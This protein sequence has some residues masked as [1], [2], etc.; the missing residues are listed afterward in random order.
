MGS[1]WGLGPLRIG[2][3]TEDISAIHWFAASRLRRRGQS[4]HPAV[5]SGSRAETRGSTGGTVQDT[6]RTNEKTA[7]NPGTSR[8]G[9]L[10]EDGRPD[11][12]SDGERSEP[13]HPVSAVG[14]R[15]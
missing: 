5:G 13:E 2:S 8:R 3:A 11:E 9:A 1:E 15:E 6:S 7:P 14:N 4:R 12:R 10:G